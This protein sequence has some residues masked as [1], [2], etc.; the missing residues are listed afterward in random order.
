MVNDFS[1]VIKVMNMLRDFMK[2][3]NKPSLEV[4]SLP[5]K[6]HKMVTLKD[7]T[8]HTWALV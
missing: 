6:Q 1:V 8:Y 2:D 7:H 4:T 5:T 3:E